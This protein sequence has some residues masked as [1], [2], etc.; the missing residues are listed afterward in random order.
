MS[1][2]TEHGER[3]SPRSSTDLK[4]DRAGH[5]IPPGLMP[6]RPAEARSECNPSKGRIVMRL[7]RAFPILAGVL[8]VVLAF[9]AFDKFGRKKK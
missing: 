5:I 9:L 1:D 7:K 2:R 4:T 6:G 8:G 3:Q